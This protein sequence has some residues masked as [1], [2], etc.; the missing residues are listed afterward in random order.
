ML[1]R[2]RQ[3]YTTAVKN[4]VTLALVSICIAIPLAIAMERRNIVKIAEERKQQAER[5]VTP[6]PADC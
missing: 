6:Q 4:T 3:A 1:T 2:V 5:V